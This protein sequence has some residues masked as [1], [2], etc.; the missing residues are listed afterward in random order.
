[1]LGLE[2]Q[3]LVQ[4]DP[5]DAGQTTTGLAGAGL[6]VDGVAG[7]LV[8]DRHVLVTL[9]EGHLLVVLRVR[10][11]PRPEVVERALQRVAVMRRPQMPLD[12]EHEQVRESRD[13]ERRRLDVLPRG[14]DTHLERRRPVR[15]L[16]REDRVENPPL[17]V[18]RRQA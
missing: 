13:T 14:D 4:R 2:V 3:R 5:L 16:L 6:E 11:D 7:V 8:D 12:T 18:V 17:L 10:L 15:C 9:V 1:M